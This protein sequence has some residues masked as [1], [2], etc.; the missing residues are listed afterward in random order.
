M[1]FLSE[2]NWDIE[3]H[4][5]NHFGQSL[6]NSNKTTVYILSQI[7]DII[8]CNEFVKSHENNENQSFKE[9]EQCPHFVK[10]YR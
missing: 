4:G 10:K 1:V 5:M 8:W 2:L 7:T 6:L 9:E 3:F